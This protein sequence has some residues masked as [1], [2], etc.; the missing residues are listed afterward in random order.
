MDANLA[1]QEGSGTPAAGA[2]TTANP[3]VGT[4]E[5]L[6]AEGR[7][8]VGTMQ[9]TVNGQS[10]IERDTAGVLSWLGQT[11]YYVTGSNLL[12]NAS[13]QMAS[14]TLKEVVYML[15][16]SSRDVAFV[17]MVFHGSGSSRI[18]VRV[19][20][21]TFLDIFAYTATTS[22]VLVSTVAPLLESETPLASLKDKFPNLSVAYVAST[23]TPPTTSSVV[24]QK[25]RVSVVAG[26][27]P[28]AATLSGEGLRPGA[29]KY[30]GVTAQP[31]PTANQ[32]VDPIDFRGISFAVGME[33]TVRSG[34]PAPIVVDGSGRRTWRGVVGGTATLL[35][36]PAGGSPLTHGITGGT[37]SAAIGEVVYFL[38][39]DMTRVDVVVMVFY[40]G[41]R[42]ILVRVSSETFLS[43]FAATARAPN[44]MVS[45]IGTSHRITPPVA[46]ESQFPNL[47]VAYQEVVDTL[48]AVG[49]VN[50]IVPRIVVVVGAIGETLGATPTLVG[51][52]INA[53]MKFGVI[54][55]VTRRMPA[56]A[57]GT[58]A[59]PT[60]NT[61]AAL[62]DATAASTGTLAA[63][64]AVSTQAA[65]SDATVA[66]T[67]TLATP[68]GKTGCEGYWAKEW[69]LCTA[70]GDAA[71]A[72][73]AT[74]AAAATGIS[75]AT[76]LYSGTS[77][78]LM[79]LKGA[80]GSL[81]GTK[82]S[83]I[84]VVK[85]GPTA[86]TE[87]TAKVI[88][89]GSGQAELLDASL[90][91]KEWVIDAKVGVPAVLGPYATAVPVV[92]VV[93]AECADLRACLKLT[94]L[95]LSKCAVQ[96]ASCKG[97]PKVASGSTLEHGDTK[98]DLFTLGADERALFGSDDR[99]VFVVSVSKDDAKKGKRLFVATDETA[100]VVDVEYEAAK[101]TWREVKGM[102]WVLIG[103][104]IGGGVALII[105]IA[106]VVYRVSRKQQPTVVAYAPPV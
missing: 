100:S 61:Q 14:A 42:R 79:P 99:G 52:R 33:D 25:A 13:G 72:T 20:A 91:D 36:V 70:D 97:Q 55:T 22:G 81:Y 18:G 5:W 93:P 48:D 63:P 89:K 12:F 84:Y 77:I 32:T 30:F 94:P 102:N 82:D 57:T 1:L 105:L 62:S 35:D 83:V 67:G 88:R 86:S 53:T 60:V 80:A 40:Q 47:K 87:S 21:R 95:D 106:V 45:T 104:L 71:C 65:L 41:S 39:A 23:E 85:P 2:V 58:L 4:V 16:A 69:P 6:G 15:D 38:S 98:V 75:T 59:A 7:Y 27:S 73:I 76:L 66:A 56:A 46:L 96:A 74:C 26:A 92:P 28:S 43:L 3:Q 44:V 50:A 54:A 49:S 24:P 19:S 34:S 103:S 9:V 78:K 17:L 64:T 51:A 90:V 31:A 10:P 8:F 37:V 68:A 29:V 11:K 101:T